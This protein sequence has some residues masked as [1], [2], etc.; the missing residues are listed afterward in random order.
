MKKGKII[1]V[2]IVAALIVFA[3]VLTGCDANSAVPS[4]TPVVSVE[5][6]PT[7]VATIEQPES[8]PTPDTV[9]LGN[10]PKAMLPDEDPD[11]DDTGKVIVPDAYTVVEDK[12]GT[13]LPD[14]IPFTV[15]SFIDVD[16]NTHYRAFGFRTGADN[17]IYDIGFYEITIENRN[18]TD[19]APVSVR[20]TA[21]AT[22]TPTATQDPIAFVTGT[23]GIVV[24]FDPVNA[25]PV[26][27]EA[28]K[29]IY[30][31][32]DG[33]KKTGDVDKGKTGD[34]DSDGEIGGSTPTPKPTTKP[35]PNPTS[36]PTTAPAPDPT[37][38]PI[39]EP[40]AVST[41]EPTVAPTPEPTVA[42]T[43]EP[44]P[45]IPDLPV[46]SNPPDWNG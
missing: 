1:I 15:Y 31:L 36:V 3:I 7:A 46:P 23:N 45:W 22:S 42:P 11:T 9:V 2:V 18:K 27:L 5:P 21:S 29:E 17:M 25:K 8:T 34:S 32:A 19:A 40:T 10:I 44:T 24:M 43:P 35:K 41:P 37:S 38:A 12:E 30:T 13:T 26:D 6:E 39:P 20:L 33:G 28:E 4:P 14:N 16:G